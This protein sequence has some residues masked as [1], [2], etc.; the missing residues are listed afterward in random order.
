MG[1]GKWV[2][3]GEGRA[4]VGWQDADEFGQYDP[5]FGYN[6]QWLDGSQQPIPGSGGTGGSKAVTLVKANI[7]ELSSGLDDEG[8]RDEDNPLEQYALVARPTEGD[9]NLNG[10][11]PDPD[12]NSPALG[13][14][15]EEP[16]K[17]NAGVTVTGVDIIQP[18]ITIHTWV[19]TE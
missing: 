14:Y 7:P 15:T 17:V 19:R 5:D 1:F 11:Q 10:C 18:F 16:I 4:L 6:N 12:D 9:L 8:S 3:Y 13:F 2:R